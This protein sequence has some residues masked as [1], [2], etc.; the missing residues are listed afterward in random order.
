[1]ITMKV[2]QT[3]T[4]IKQA[5]VTKTDLSSSFQNGDD[6]VQMQ[7]D[8]SLNIFSNEI[9]LIFNNFVP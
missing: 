2:K 1:M 4:A 5:R 9:H 6:F 8:V 7:A 3:P